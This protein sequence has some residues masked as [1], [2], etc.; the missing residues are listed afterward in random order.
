MI[1]RCRKR[2]ECSNCTLQELKLIYFLLGFILTLGSNCT[3]QELK[4]TLRQD[5]KCRFLFKLYLT[6]IET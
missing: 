3:L 2:D 5:G 4:R 6:G 1:K